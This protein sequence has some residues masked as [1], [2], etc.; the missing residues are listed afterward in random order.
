MSTRALR[1]IQALATRL[2]TVAIGDDQTPLAAVY[3]GREDLFGDDLTFPCAS[4]VEETEEPQETNRAKA[5]C[6]VSYSV[7]GITKSDPQAPLIAGH[8]LW[9]ALML[10]LFPAEAQRETGFDRL[11]GLAT[12]VTYTGRAI[13]PREDGGQTTSVL[14]SMTVEYVLDT[15]NPSN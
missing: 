5:K 12:R 3:L 11:C 8:A 4:I 14:I 13:A 6:V 1:I 15:T 2:G 7:I 10:A 9:D